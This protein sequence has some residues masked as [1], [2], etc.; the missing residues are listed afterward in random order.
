MDFRLFVLRDVFLYE[1]NKDVLLMKSTKNK[2]LFAK[3]GWAANAARFSLCFFGKKH[4]FSLLQRVF[5]FQNGA[6]YHFRYVFFRKNSAQKCRKLRR[7]C[8]KNL[9]KFCLS[10][11][12]TEILFG[13][14]YEHINYTPRMIFISAKKKNAGKNKRADKR[15]YKKNIFSE[16]F[17]KIS[18]PFHINFINAVTSPPKSAPHTAVIIDVMIL[19]SRFCG[20][21][22]I[23]ESRASWMVSSL[24]INSICATILDMF[25]FCLCISQ[26]ISSSL[27]IL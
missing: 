8:R 26:A 6:F 2:F 11:S 25:S 27:S 23:S 10:L 5:H 20:R 3:R 7:K 24:F 17:R 19:P 21:L 15:T 18:T 22:S 16:K 9:R 4:T 1:G 12:G 13:F 14:T